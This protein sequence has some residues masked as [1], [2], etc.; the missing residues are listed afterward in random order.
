M[1]VEGLWT[2]Y[3]KMNKYKTIIQEWFCFKV[4]LTGDAVTTMWLNESP[5]LLS[6]GCNDILTP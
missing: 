6:L 5:F 1:T 2:L 4:H 3:K